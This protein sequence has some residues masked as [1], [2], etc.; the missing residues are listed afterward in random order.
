MVLM[1]LNEV[2][3]R[4]IMHPE[5]YIKHWHSFKF[6]FENSIIAKIQPSIIQI[7]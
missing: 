7:K 1:M 3:L 6:A 5:E 2:K 4:K